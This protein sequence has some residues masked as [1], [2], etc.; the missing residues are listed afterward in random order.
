MIY[1]GHNHHTSQHPQPFHLAACRYQGLHD[2]WREGLRGL[3][4]ERM[5]SHEEAC[6][7]R[8]LAMRGHQTSLHRCWRYALL[9]GLLFYSSSAHWP[10]SPLQHHLLLLAFLDLGGSGCV[11]FYR[12]AAATRRSH[13]RLVAHEAGCNLYSCTPGGL[14]GFPHDLSG[15]PAKPQRE[16]ASARPERGLGSDSVEPY[17]H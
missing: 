17:N 5:G 12:G 9:V 6:W 13:R 15:S 11:S 7:W 3:R 10:D 16:T 14:L 4:C 1:P 2:W 8:V